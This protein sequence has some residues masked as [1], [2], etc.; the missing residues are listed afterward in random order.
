[1]MGS[2]DQEQDAEGRGEIAR[3]YRIPALS[4]FETLR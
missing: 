3:D 4:A 2:A 1:M